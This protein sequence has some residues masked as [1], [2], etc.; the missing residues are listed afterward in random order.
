[1]RHSTTAFA[2]S[3]CLLTLCGCSRAR[4]VPSPPEIIR[5]PV[6]VELPAECRVLQPVE[7][8]PG[9]TAQDVMQKQHAAIL[10]Y[11]KQIAACFS[12]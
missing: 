7:L 9:S 11:E 12:R 8:P 3:L 1:M 6:P 10:L 5:V 2:T 4:V